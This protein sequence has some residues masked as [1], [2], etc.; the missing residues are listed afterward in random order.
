MKG[1]KKIR[2]NCNG[3]TRGYREKVLVRIQPALDLV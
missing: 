1:S 2:W 3:Y